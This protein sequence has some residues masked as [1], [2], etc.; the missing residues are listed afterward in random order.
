MLTPT[1]KLK[2]DR[3]EAV[4]AERVEGLASPEPV[5]WLPA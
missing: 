1:L 4:Y 5:V 3:I 2:R